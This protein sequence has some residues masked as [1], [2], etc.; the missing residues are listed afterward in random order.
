MHRF[1]A[2]EAGAIKVLGGGRFDP[3]G[4]VSAEWDAF[5]SYYMI[6]PAV[7]MVRSL[8]GTQTLQSVLSLLSLYRS[9]RFGTVCCTP[10]LLESARVVLRSRET[11]ACMAPCMKVPHASRKL[12]C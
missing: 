6:L 5:G 2:D 1:L 3:H 8:H 10:C 4:S 11:A 12:S 7:E 9:V